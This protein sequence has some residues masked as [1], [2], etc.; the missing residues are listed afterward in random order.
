M[1]RK[2]FY[3]QLFRSLSLGLHNYSSP[4]ADTENFEL[5]ELPGYITTDQAAG[6]L[7]ISKH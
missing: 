5:P 6:I 2:A 3:N 4:I 1:E 7:G